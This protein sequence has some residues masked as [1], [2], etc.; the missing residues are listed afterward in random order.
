VST[1]F[2][3]KYQDLEDTTQSIVPDN[4]NLGQL[5]ACIR[6]YADFLSMVYDMTHTAKQL[7]SWLS[8]TDL[9]EE[10]TPKTGDLKYY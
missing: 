9:M 1:E 6:E 4:E 10:L 2:Q 3:E 8:F 7:K 5:S